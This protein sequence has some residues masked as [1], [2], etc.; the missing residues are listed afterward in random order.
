MAMP[1][2]F[3]EKRIQ[4][5]GDAYLNKIAQHIYDLVN[6]EPELL[7]GESTGEINRRV[8]LAM[9]YDSGLANILSGSG[10]KLADFKQ[11]Y[12]AKNCATE[13]E[14]ARAL[15][16]MLSDDIIRLPASV[17]KKSEQFKSRISSSMR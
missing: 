1:D 4:I 11:W 10:N 16:A 13:E 12:L 6:R 17:I 2:M 15:R 3:G 7:N 8:H 14:T 9:M 5:K